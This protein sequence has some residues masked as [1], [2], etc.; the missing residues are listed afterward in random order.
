MDPPFVMYHERQSLMKCGIHCVNNLLGEHCYKTEDFEA[1]AEELCPRSWWNP[2][3]AIFGIGNY[4][5]NVLQMSLKKKQ[6]YT[7]WFDKR[8]PFSSEKSLKDE[9]VV[10]LILNICEGWIRWSR[11]WISFRKIKNKWFNCDSILE[12]PIMFKNTAHMVSFVQKALDESHG[13][14]LLVLKE[15]V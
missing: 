2:H 1:I 8:E 12:R 11:H 6:L 13:E 14:V 4:D 10:G 15:E 7:K 3:K 5:V 9:S